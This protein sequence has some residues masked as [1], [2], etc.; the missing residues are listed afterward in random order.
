MKILKACYLLY[1]IYKI[2]TMNYLFYIMLKY[3]GML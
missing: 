1:K 2:D 3:I